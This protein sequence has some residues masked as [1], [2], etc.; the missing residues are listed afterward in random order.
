MLKLTKHN[1]GNTITESQ[2]GMGVI[3]PDEP[4]SELVAVELQRSFQ[5]IYREHDAIYIAE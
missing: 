4:V 5:I 3:P 2:P 1:F